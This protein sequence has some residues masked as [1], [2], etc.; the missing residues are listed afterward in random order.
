MVSV[1][2]HYVPQLYLRG[3]T[4]NNGRL[5]IFDKKHN[6]F[7]ADKQTPKTVCFDKHRNTIDFKGVRSDVVEKLYSSIESPFG[8]FFECIRKGISQEELV[9]KDGIYLLKTFIAT[10]FW[11][12]PLVDVMADKYVLNL[13]LNKLGHCIT[14][15][16][17]NL[18]AIENF[19]E[20]IENDKGFRHYFR[21]FF[22][23]LLTFDRRVYEHDYSCWRLHSVS[24][25]FNGWDNFLTGDNPLVV[26]NISDIFSFKSKLIFPLSKN[27][28]ISYSPDKR[29]H[30]VL[31]QMFTSKLAMVM[32]SQSIKY[33]VGANRSYMEEII[34]LQS[35]MYGTDEVDKLRCELFEYI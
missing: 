19:K 15:N 27:Q 28:L 8:H 29:I 34:E 23:P 26:E 25:D 14:I 31:P 5:Q 9:S 4:A 35:D 10:Q 1:N 17:E 30:G 3:F 12:M 16:G 11:R 32:N 6:S 20:L 18:G 7:K 2:H 22:L 13:D 33:L 21:S 24:S